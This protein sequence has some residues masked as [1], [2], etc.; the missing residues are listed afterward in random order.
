MSYVNEKF[1]KIQNESFKLVNRTSHTYDV[2]VFI[3]KNVSEFI[4]SNTNLSN[5]LI[6]LILMKFRL[7]SKY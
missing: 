3:N 7:D 1:V 5:N 4:V 2:D 6:E